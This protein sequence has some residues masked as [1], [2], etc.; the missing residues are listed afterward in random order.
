VG[1]VLLKLIFMLYSV[2]SLEH[3]FCSTL[4]SLNMCEAETWMLNFYFVSRQSLT[5][6]NGKEPVTPLLVCNNAIPGNTVFREDYISGHCTKLFEDRNPVLASACLSLTPN[7]TTPYVTKMGGR[8]NKD[9]CKKDVFIF[10]KKIWATNLD[11]W[12]ALGGRIV[13]SSCLASIVGA[14]AFPHG[15]HTC[16]PF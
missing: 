8:C 6:F 12:F 14:N 10:W 3:L 16:L 1:D 9:L 15:I 4:R 7:V 11:W 5:S 13:K 2:Y